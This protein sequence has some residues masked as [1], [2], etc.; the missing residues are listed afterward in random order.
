MFPDQPFG[1]L[2]QLFGKRKQHKG[3]SKIE[4]RMKDGDLRS[5]NGGFCPLAVDGEHQEQNR[6]EAGG[7]G[8]IE[9]KVD[10]GGLFCRFICGCGGKEGSHTGADVLSKGNGNGT[11]PGDDA[12]HGQCLKNAH[13]SGRALDNGG[14]GQAGQDAEDGIFPKDSENPQK[15]RGI[16]VRGD[17]SGQKA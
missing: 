5:G 8:H 7:S 17:G 10:H 13:G 12:V 11:A 6:T 15:R 4:Y 9:K 16:P 3:S 14:D 1:E 2:Y